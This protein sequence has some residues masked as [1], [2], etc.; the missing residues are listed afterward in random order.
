M[1]AVQWYEDL[2]PVRAAPEP[3]GLEAELATFLR[4]ATGRADPALL[5]SEQ[6]PAGADTPDVLAGALRR[7]LRR[8]V[9]AVADGP[10]GPWRRHAAAVLLVQRRGASEVVLSPP[11]GG[12]GRRRAFRLRAAACLLVPA[13]WSYRL[14]PRGN[15]QPFA[16]ALP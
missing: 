9:L 10:A 7:E 13:S 12:A 5:W 1:A 4:G 2:E 8:T 14:D 11:P 6:E 15:G 16:L 3:G